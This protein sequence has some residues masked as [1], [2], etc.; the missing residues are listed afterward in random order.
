MARQV[1]RAVVIAVAL[2]LLSIPAANAA[3][4]YAAPGGS[5]KDPCRNPANPCSVHLAADA[6]ARGTTIE[7]GDV[8][9]LA[10]GT[11]VAESEGEFGF[12]P[13]VVL[14]GGVSVRG[15]LGK[16]RPRI[17][18]RDN[19]SYGAF[20][21]PEGAEVADVV[22]RDVSGQG[23]GIAVSGGTLDRVVVRTTSVEPACNYTEGTIRSSACINT[24]GGI[25]IG[26][27]NVATKGSLKGVIRD[28][29]FVA[30]G[31]GS[32]GMNLVYS[33]FKRGL[34]VRIDAAGVLIE[35]EEAD[36]VLKGWPLNK[37]RGAE[38][39]LTLRN[40]SYKTVETE[41]KAGG[42]A[43]VTRPGT[44]GNITESPLLAP[45]YLHQV[46]GSPTIDRGVADS[47]SGALDI[48]DEPRTIGA[49]VDIGADEFSF[50]APHANA[51][52][53]TELVQAPFT[54]GHR[55]LITPERKAEFEFGSSDIDSRFEC[56]LDDRPYRPCASPYRLVVGLGRHV[57]RVRAVDPQGRVDP[58]PAVFRWRV[59]RWR[60]FL[61]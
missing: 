60:F 21:V 41:A 39:E 18:V 7:A 37:G 42:R 56:K 14:P 46:P 9:E 29:T 40:S 51:A 22:I 15:E 30:T 50:L 11:Y 26:V 27:N 1:G 34:T 48:D 28:S 59:L 31:P 32:V 16:R 35:G 49:A 33:A 8:V 5:G 58:T 36:V 24:A 53:V 55:N 52:P 23:P 10:P 20:Y 12:I 13:S 25:A 2:V 61:P 43:F 47:D 6:H 17:V 44:N 38:A 54:G 45:D 57:F 3:I 19:E 4:R